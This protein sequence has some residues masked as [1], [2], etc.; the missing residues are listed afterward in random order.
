MTAQATPNN[1]IQPVQHQRPIHNFKIPER[2]QTYGIESL[3]MVELTA[4]EEIAATKR[5]NNNAMQLAYELAKESLRMV[6]G[7]RVATHDGTADT[8]FNNMHPMV[9]TL[10]AQAYSAIHSPKDEDSKDFLSSREYA[11]G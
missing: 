8:A 3:G 1:I 7:K 5:S 4:N 10:V 2:L 11:A 9:R 6:N